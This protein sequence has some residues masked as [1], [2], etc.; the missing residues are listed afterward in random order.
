MSM[1][2]S[3]TRLFVCDQ[4]GATLPV[5]PEH[6]GK[7]CRCGKCGKVMLV[8]GDASDEPAE[9]TPQ[10]VAFNCILCDTRLSARVEDVGLKAKCPD[11]G[12]LTKVPPPPKPRPKRIPKSMH[13]QQYGLWGVD[14]APLPKEIAEATRARYIEAY[15]RISGLSFDDWIGVSA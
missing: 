13:G 9:P 1:P 12:K 4:C 6:A 3:P 11:C 7:K 5:E 14:E 15:E 10:Y 2:S 8:P